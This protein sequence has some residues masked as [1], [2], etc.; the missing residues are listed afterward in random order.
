[1]SELPAQCICSFS[2]SFNAINGQIP[3]S[4]KHFLSLQLDYS[5]SHY[6]EDVLYPDGSFQSNTQILIL[7]EI[8]SLDKTDF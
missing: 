4:L 2:N 3:I 5:P 7:R 1:M 6:A 8:Y